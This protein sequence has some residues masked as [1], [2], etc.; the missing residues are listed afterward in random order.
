MINIERRDKIDIVTFTVKKINALVT[1]EIRDSILRILDNSNPQV[2][3][4][5]K[6]VEYIDSSGFGSL[7]SVMKVARNNFGVLKFANP[8]PAVNE[9]MEILHLYDVFQ[10]Y[11]NMEDCLKSFR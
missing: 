8:E 6:G 9:S 3:I 10:I 5:L 7:L 4:D 1:E 11:P 2:I